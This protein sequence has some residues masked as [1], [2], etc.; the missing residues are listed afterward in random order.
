MSKY[1]DADDL[2]EKIKEAQT[3]L[4]SDNDAIWQ[5]NQKYYKG[6]AW[7]N[8]LVQDATAVDA[9]EVVPGYHVGDVCFYGF[10]SQTNCL[11]L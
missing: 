5:L 10:G 1:I 9:V 8:R 7:A 2:L 11:P 6:L 4:V 3:S